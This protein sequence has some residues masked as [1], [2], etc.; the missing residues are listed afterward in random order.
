[1]QQQELEALRAI[2]DDDM[3]PLNDSATCFGIKMKFL[4]DE[5]EA[6]DIIRIWFR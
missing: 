1:M 6:N 3:T 5:M 4:S 2:Y